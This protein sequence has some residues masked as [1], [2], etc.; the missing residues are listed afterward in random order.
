MPQQPCQ[1]IC[2]NFYAW[3]SY[4]HQLSLI[5]PH[6]SKITQRMQKCNNKKSQKCN[7][8]LT[9]YDACAILET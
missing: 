4:V 2:P 7:L 9:D 8:L 1:Q 5:S 6:A 3:P